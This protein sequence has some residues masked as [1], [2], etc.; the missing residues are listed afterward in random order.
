[1]FSIKKN[2]KTNFEISKILVKFSW[3]DWI[4]LPTVLGG[5]IQFFILIS[6]DFSFIRFF[7]IEQ[8]VPDGF[9][10]LL[11]IFFLYVLA[12]N[13]F[14]KEDFFQ[15]I[16]LGWCK[17]N[18]LINLIRP[19]TLIVIEFTIMILLFFNPFDLNVKI[20]SFMTILLKIL[21][22]LAFL[23]SYYI[24]FYLYYFKDKVS[25]FEINDSEYIGFLK[26]WTLSY[27]KLGYF[28]LPV[29]LFLI[30]YFTSSKELKTIYTDFFDFKKLENQT[31]I[32]KR[33][34]EKQNINGELKVEYFNGKYVFIKNI[35]NG[36]YLVIKGE[37]FVNL[38]DNK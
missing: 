22:I 23:R 17:S 32:I 10:S 16:T 36:N 5:V 38:L 30:F 37:E 18:I 35:S 6:M 20:V 1:M 7:A 24:V 2:E 26:K 4:L 34:A 29:I 27:M 31:L 15:K 19:I 11:I 8:V 28:T 33:L 13:L 21:I 14:E 9:L 25:P 3:K 12:Q